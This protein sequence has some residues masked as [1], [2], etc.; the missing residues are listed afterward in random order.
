VA[1]I[2]KIP[3]VKSSQVGQF[4]GRGRRE[5]RSATTPIKLGGFLAHSSASPV[6]R[7]QVL[8]GKAVVVMQKSQQP[9]QE[10]GRV[11]GNSRQP[12]DQGAIEAIDS[13]SRPML[14]SVSETSIAM[15]RLFTLSEMKVDTPLF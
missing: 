7:R 2:P 4:V 14:I 12:A 9:E 3:L 13:R 1:D 8:W 15:F 11:E 10:F 6:L 5:F